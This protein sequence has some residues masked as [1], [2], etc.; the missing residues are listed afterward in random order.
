MASHRIPKLTRAAFCLIADV[1]KNSHICTADRSTL[2]AD[3]TSAL[4]ATNQNFNADRFRSA[5]Q[6]TADR[7][8]A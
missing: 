7:R 3:F 5:C 8:A 6:P 2:T 4:Y 1:I